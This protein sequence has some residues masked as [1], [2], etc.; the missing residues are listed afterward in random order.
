[1][2]TIPSAAS[3]GFIVPYLRSF[4]F[5]LDEKFQF[6][7]VFD[8]GKEKNYFKWKTFSNETKPT[9]FSDQINNFTTS[10]GAK[11]INPQQLSW[12]N[13]GG[14]GRSS[15]LREYWN[16]FSMAATQSVFNNQETCLTNFSQERGLG[17]YSFISI[18]NHHRHTCWTRCNHKACHPFCE[19]EIGCPIQKVWL[20]DV[21]SWRIVTLG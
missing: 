18:I 19:Q 21:Q 2:K 3:N 6:T 14:G 7:L 4:F 13:E 20:S 10:F 9:S 8:H 17:W 5:L 11:S 16:S 15:A 12:K 1:M